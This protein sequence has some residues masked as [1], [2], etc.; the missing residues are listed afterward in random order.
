MS[1]EQAK[2]IPLTLR[3]KAFIKEDEQEITLPLE[4]YSPSERRR[5]VNKLLKD[6][7]GI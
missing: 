5:I 4:I 6:K 1:K 2:K 3:Y 7:F